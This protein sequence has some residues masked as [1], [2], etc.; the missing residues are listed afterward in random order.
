MPDD[1]TGKT[2]LVSATEEKLV[3]VVA[4]LVNAGSEDDGI[5]IVSV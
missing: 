5:T 1:F 3:D 2:I 4:W